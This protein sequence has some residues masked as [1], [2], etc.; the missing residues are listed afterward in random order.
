M[1]VVTINGE[2]IDKKLTRKIKNLKDEFAYY[3]IGVIDVEN[4]GDCFQVNNIFYTLE[5]GRIVWDEY[6]KHY[7]LKT[8][9]VEGIVDINLRRGYFNKDVP[10]SAIVYLTKEPISELCMATEIAEDLDLINGEHNLYYNSKYYT[11]DQI[12]PRQSI[13]RNYKNSLPYNFRDCIKECSKNFDKFNFIE[14]DRTE[15]QYSQIKNLLNTYSFG[16]EIETTQGMIPLEM[17]EKLGVRPLRDGSISGLEYVTIP[18]TGKKGFYAFIKIVE[19]INKYTSHDYTCAMH[20]H[21]GN[22]PRTMKFIVAMYKTMY[23]LQDEIYRLFPSYKQFDNGIKK[24]CYTAPLDSHVMASLNYN[25]N[26]DDELKQ[27][28]Q[29]IVY[30]LSGRHSEY[31]NFVDLASIQNH[32]YDPS[33]NSKWNMKARYKI[34]NL[35]PLIFTNKQTVEYRIFTV[36]D[37]VEKAISFLTMALSITDF[38]ASHNHS[39]IRSQSCINPIS[40]SRIF[41]HTLNNKYDSLNHL[42]TRERVVTDHINN[43]GSFFEEKDINLKYYGRSVKNMGRSTALQEELHE[44]PSLRELRRVLQQSPRL[45]INRTREGIVA[46]NVIEEP[47]IS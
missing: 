21:V 12:L 19:L 30:E 36:P 40:L 14:N 46:N 7:V 33:E 38:V 20:I 45:F 24:R 17:Y 43:K 22:I 5:K 37:T 25:C 26:T 41:D 2:T 10:N 16:I 18:L 32:P 9:T 31:R 39:V 34:Q 1:N 6:L 28:Y 13:D 29:K 35:I 4:S 23:H 47:G 11:Y 27:D 44:D 3:K 8:T 15:N 42:Q